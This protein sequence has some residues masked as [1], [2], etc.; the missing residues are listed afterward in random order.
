MKVFCS[1]YFDIAC[2]LFRPWNELCNTETK[3]PIEYFV[4]TS[5][6]GY[7]E[8]CIRGDP[9]AEQVAIC[10]ETCA[11]CFVVYHKL[12]PREIPKYFSMLREELLRYRKIIKRLFSL[13]WR[14]L[15]EF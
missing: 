7:L 4:S 8:Q 2:C 10:T 11:V 12:S 14:F 15:P 5:K 9:V 6:Q 13:V 1:P 3:H